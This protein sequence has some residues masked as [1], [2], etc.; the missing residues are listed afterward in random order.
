MPTVRSKVGAVQPH[1]Y[2]AY[3]ATA[4]LL[5]LDFKCVINPYSVY[6]TER[7]WG[8]GIMSDF[9]S[10][11]LRKTLEVKL[12]LVALCREEDG[13]R[14]IFDLFTRHA[15]TIMATQQPNGLAFDK[16][17]RRQSPDLRS[18]TPRERRRLGEQQ[19]METV[20]RRASC[21]CGQLSVTA[22]GAPAKIS[23][24]HCPACQRRTGS[25]FG[26]AVFFDRKKVAASGASSSYTRTGDSG[27]SVEFMFCPTCG[28]RSIGVPNSGKTSSQSHWGAST[29]RPPW[30]RRK[31]STRKAEWDG[32]GSTYLV[33]IQPSASPKPVRQYEFW[34]QRRRPWPVHDLEL[35][36]TQADFRL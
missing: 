6:A 34:K 25:A 16:Q 35:H 9:L 29:N 5:T 3:G 11:R 33:E 28:R 4:M 12:E 21:S 30:F 22:E 10:T 26:V 13:Y 31:A 18:R 1:S 32:W 19:T 2:M 27:R 17:R 8:N 7:D 15:A 14:T 24:C 20:R 36:R 23:A